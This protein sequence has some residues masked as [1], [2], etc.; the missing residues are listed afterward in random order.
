VGPV[1]EKK[2]G[3]GKECVDRIAPRSGEG[4]EK[5]KE[6]TAVSGLNDLLHLRGRGE[7]E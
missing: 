4:E 7:K 1:S 3:E 2:K 5:E 6:R